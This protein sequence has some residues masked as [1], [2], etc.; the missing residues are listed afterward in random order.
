MLN[1][2]ATCGTP[3]HRL[4][5]ALYTIQRRSSKALHGSWSVAVG[6]LVSQTSQCDTTDTPGHEG[7]ASR[8]REKP[9]GYRRR[10]HCSADAAGTSDVKVTGYVLGSG[11]YL[12]SR[13][14]ASITDRTAYFTKALRAGRRC[15]G[16]L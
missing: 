2:S 1:G 9:A 8:C 14:L 15:G 4:K 7:A 12:I 10:Y 3:Y 16:V 5:S 13:P 6:E 11:A